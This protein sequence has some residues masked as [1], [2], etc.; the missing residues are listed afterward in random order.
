MYLS[1]QGILLVDERENMKVLESSKYSVYIS[2]CWCRSGMILWGLQYTSHEPHKKNSQRK[3]PQVLHLSSFSS[4]PSLTMPLC[5]CV[6]ILSL[7]W[8]N[9]EFT[10]LQ[11]A[12]DLLCC[13][14]GCSNPMVFSFPLP[15]RPKL[16]KFKDQA[17]KQERKKI[18]NQ[19]TT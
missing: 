8:P 18:R 16:T 3:T 1:R 2:G 17:S 6:N 9:I 11:P 19:W 12:N 13:F 7:A 4:K 14:N 15:S 5:L 10:G